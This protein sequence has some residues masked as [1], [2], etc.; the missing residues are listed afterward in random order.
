MRTRALSLGFGAI[1][2]LTATQPS[3]A[4]TASLY[5]WC[6][7]DFGRL[8]PCSY[9]GG[10][11]CRVTMSGLGVCVPSPSIPSYRTRVLVQH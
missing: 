1:A 4:Y 9:E 11:Q 2:L 7:G 3:L 6:I 10:R 5:G 8:D